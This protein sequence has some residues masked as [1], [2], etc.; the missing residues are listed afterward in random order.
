MRRPTLMDVARAAGVSRST[1]SY[2]YNEPVAGVGRDTRTRV[3]AAAAEVGFGGP[4]PARRHCGA[5]GP[6]RSG[7]S[8]PRSCPTPR[9]PAAVLFLRGVASVAERADVALTLLPVPPPADAARRR[10]SAAAP[11]TA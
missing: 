1:A 5:A 3:L 11:S 2:A 8:S 9:R 7:S 4:D 10:R 6:A